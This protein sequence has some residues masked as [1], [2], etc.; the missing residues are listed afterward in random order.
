MQRTL[1][2]QKSRS[3]TCSQKDQDSLSTNAFFLPSP[4]RDYSHRGYRGIWAACNFSSD[5]SGLRFT[6]AAITHRT[7]QN[8]DPFVSLRVVIFGAM[9]LSEANVGQKLHMSRSLH[10]A[11]LLHKFLL[12]SVKFMIDLHGLQYEI[13]AGGPPLNLSVLK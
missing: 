9:L 13:C 2:I 3:R 5:D 12:E 4:R 10:Q 6:F 7:L 11:A 8:S 1:L